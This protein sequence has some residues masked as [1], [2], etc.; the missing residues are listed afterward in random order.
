MTILF[1]VK[2]KMSDLTVLECAM[3]TTKSFGLL[4]T[5]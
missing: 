3:L 4:F 1:C 5:K 2:R